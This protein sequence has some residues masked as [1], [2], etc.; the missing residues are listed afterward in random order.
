MQT[1]LFNWSL[2]QFQTFLLILMRVAFILFMMPLFGARNLPNLLKAGFTLSI[3]LLLLPVVKI[4]AAFFPTEPFQFLF[5]MISECLIGF[6]LGLSIKV[7]FAGIQLAGEFAGFQMGLAMA[8]IVDPQSGLDNTLMAQLH[9]FLGLLLFLS[10]DGHHWF[11]R[12]L[13]QSFHLLSPGELYFKEGVYRYLLSLSGRMFL[14]G[15]KLAAP[16]TVILI[17]TQVALGIIARTVPQV[18]VLMT[19]FPLTIGLGLIFLGLSLELMLPYL[20]GLFDE[21]GRE[22]STVLLPLMAR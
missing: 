19:S 10:I 8:Q 4:N 22:L 20:Q 13:V 18:N 14:I 1:N 2:T 11:F 7:V 6:I 17:L 12:A 3:G 9:Y 15:I 16:V 5:L 21:S